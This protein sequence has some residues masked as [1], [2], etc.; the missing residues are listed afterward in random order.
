VERYEI[1]G[2]L[3]DVLRTCG[4]SMGITAAWLRPICQKSCENKE[5]NAYLLVFKANLSD[6][7]SQLLN[8]I[9]LRHNL[10]MTREQGQWVVSRKPIQLVEASF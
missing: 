8:P 10:A 1:L 5:R 2:F 7:E 9:L 6:Y 4:E 3:E